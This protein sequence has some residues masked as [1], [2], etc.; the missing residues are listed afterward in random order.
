MLTSNAVVSMMLECK[1]CVD[2]HRRRFVGQKKLFVNR[3]GT[4]IN[5]VK[6][7]VREFKLN[8]SKHRIATCY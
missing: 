8:D 3:R 6:T 2:Q 4:N 7:V 1:L 5:S